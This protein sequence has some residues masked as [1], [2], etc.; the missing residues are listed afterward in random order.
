MIQWGMSP[1]QAIKTAT[2]TAAELLDQQG[3]IGEIKV[4]AFADII[5]VKGDA[6]KNIAVLNDVKFVM[7]DG[8]VYKSAK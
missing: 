5:A 3:K 2:T 4:G 8:V 1:L 6:T 7:K